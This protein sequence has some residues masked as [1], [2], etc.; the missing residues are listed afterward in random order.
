MNRDNPVHE[1]DAE[2]VTDGGCHE[3]DAEKYG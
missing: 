2:G 3:N 1:D